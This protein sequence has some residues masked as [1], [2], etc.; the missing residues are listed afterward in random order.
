MQIK[1]NNNIISLIVPIY[2]RS[3]FLPACITS[4]I[5]QSYPHLDIILVDDGS[6]DNSFDICKEYAQNDKR[7]TVISIPNSGVS[8]ARNTGIQHAKGDFI[9]FVDSDDM[10]KQ[11]ACEILLN[12]QKK[13]DADLVICGFYNIDSNGN[14]LSDDYS[15]SPI[16]NLEDFYKNFGSLLDKNLLR[17]PVNKL[18]KKTVIDEHKIGFNSDFSIAED[19][20]FNLHYYRYMNSPVVIRDTLYICTDH[21]DTSRLTRKPH[22]NYFKIQN[23]YFEQ[24]VN[25]LKTKNAY[26]KQNRNTVMYQY[27]QIL[28][29]GLEKKAMHNESL[30]LDTLH[31]NILWDIFPVRHNFDF[32]SN[33]VTLWIEKKQENKLLYAFTN[34]ACKKKFAAIKYTQ[35]NKKII[36]KIYGVLKIIFWQ[37]AEIISILR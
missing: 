14:H 33:K 26:T 15:D 24:L 10:I 18:Y 13:N 17:S 28:I 21:N 2:N 5:N 7:I 19:G 11:N 27:L 32:V 8:T 36:H 16:S 22:E 29:T 35:Y 3:T 9:Q 34:T 37:C 6:T 4:I 1:K 31:K 23:I 25:L 20:L 12:E 30:D